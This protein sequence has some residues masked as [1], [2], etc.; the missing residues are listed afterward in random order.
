M[1]LIHKTFPL[2]AVLLEVHKPEHILTDMELLVTEECREELSKTRTA[3][4]T[5]LDYYLST[6]V[7][8]FDVFVVKLLV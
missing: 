2:S 6:W 5:E 8:S 7:Q 3:I 4:L 1:L